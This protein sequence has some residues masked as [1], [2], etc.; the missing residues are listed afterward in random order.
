MHVSVLL[1][2]IVDI[3]AEKKKLREKMEKTSGAIRGKE[4]MLSKADFVDKAPKEIVDKEK[5]RLLEL[6][7]TLERYCG[8]YEEL[9]K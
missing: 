2:G 9:Q 5:A 8:I 6:K 7:E 3:S 1:E 4:A